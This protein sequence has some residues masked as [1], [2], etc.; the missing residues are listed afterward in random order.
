MFGRDV[1]TAGLEVRL[2]GYRWKRVGME[3]P[4]ERLEREYLEENMG[5]NS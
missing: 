5:G 3:G 2:G 1:E 4:E